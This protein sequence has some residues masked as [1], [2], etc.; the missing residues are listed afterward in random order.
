MTARLTDDQLRELLELEVKA[1][2]SEWIWTRTQDLETLDAMLDHM[3]AHFEFSAVRTISGVGIPQHPL[4]DSDSG[5][6]VLSAITGNGPTSD[7]NAVFICAARN[8]IR[9][10]VEELL[11]A[12]KLLREVAEQRLDPGLVRQIENLLG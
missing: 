2:Q 4:S 3:R 7:D 9:P 10:L 1:S 8:V 12:R 5:H 11:E 6:M